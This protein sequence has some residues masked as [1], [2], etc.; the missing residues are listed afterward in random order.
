M[1]IKVNAAPAHLRAG[2]LAGAA[3]DQ[4]RIKSYPPITTRAIGAAIGK[5]IRCSKA[6][7]A[8]GIMVEVNDRIPKNHAPRNPAGFRLMSAHTVAAASAP[9]ITPNGRISRMLLAAGHM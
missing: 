1:T 2:S 5:Y 4:R 7:S 8:K 3:D 6:R 9:M